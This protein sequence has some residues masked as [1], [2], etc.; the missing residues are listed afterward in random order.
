MSPRLTSGASSCISP[1]EVLQVIAAAGG[2]G[3]V[4]GVS[5]FHPFTRHDVGVTS[6]GGVVVIMAHSHAEDR[7]WIHGHCVKEQ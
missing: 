2:P 3:Q 4:A 7:T 1:E 5:S 6:A